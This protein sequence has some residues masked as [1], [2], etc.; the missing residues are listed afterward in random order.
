MRWL[1]LSASSLSNKIEEQE[2]A[3]TKLELFVISFIKNK[4]TLPVPTAKIV[5][6]GKTD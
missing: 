5:S 3:G 2:V 6:V 1:S 4:M